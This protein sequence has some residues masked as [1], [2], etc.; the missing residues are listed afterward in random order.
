MLSIRKRCK[1]VSSDAIMKTPE[2][3]LM[4]IIGWYVCFS[5]V[6][7][8]SKEQVVLPPPDTSQF[9]NELKAEQE[10]LKRELECDPSRAITP[11]EQFIIKEGS[12]ANKRALELFESGKH[13][14]AKTQWEEGAMLYK[15]LARTAESKSV[16]CLIK[17]T[18]AESLREQKKFDK[19]FDDL[20]K[21]VRGVKEKLGQ[22]LGGEHPITVML[23]M[24][25]ADAL[26]GGAFYEDAEKEYRGVLL[27]Q[28]RTLRRDH[29]DTLS[30]RLAIGMCLATRMDK[31]KAAEKEFREILDIRTH[32]L[33]AQ[34]PETLFAQ[35]RLASTLY[36]QGNFEEA[37]PHLQQIEA[38]LPKLNLKEHPEYKNVTIM[39]ERAEQIS[40]HLRPYSQ[41]NKRN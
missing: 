9:L 31:F 25:L 10:K 12:D 16:E 11:Q 18:A 8:S 38:N 5:P 20:V 34:H 15:I 2:R 1:S 13:A 30:C 22:V 33:G 14:K 21:N 19:V 27:I 23:R 40:K 39:R 24:Y 35:F 32:L 7:A 36:A 17:K 26:F 29:P 41:S 3:L 37:I 6:V 4:Y 28:E